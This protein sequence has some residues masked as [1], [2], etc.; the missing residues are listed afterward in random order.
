[1]R[2]PEA[3]AL[4]AVLLLYVLVTGYFLMQFVA[5]APQVFDLIGALVWVVVTVAFVRQLL[6]NRFLISMA[7]AAVFVVIA[8]SAGLALRQP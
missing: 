4:G 8:L 2:W 3:M 6:Q 5:T 7:F 1:M